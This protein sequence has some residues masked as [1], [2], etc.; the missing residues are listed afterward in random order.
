MD[1]GVKIEVH[2]DCL[3]EIG[4]NAGYDKSRTSPGKQ[5]SKEKQ[6]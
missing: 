5:C 4:G 1:L 6:N 3:D 2:K